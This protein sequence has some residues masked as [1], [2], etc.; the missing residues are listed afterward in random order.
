[1][2]RKRGGFGSSQH[3]SWSFAAMAVPE[4]S[5]YKHCRPTCSSLIHSVDVSS[6]NV[7]AT[8]PGGKT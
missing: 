4:L 3:H 8:E 2:C 6:E 5:T 1:M 7:T